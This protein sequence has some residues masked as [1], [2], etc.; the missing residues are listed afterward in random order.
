MCE[1][2]HLLDPTLKGVALRKLEA[3]VDPLV[4]IL[5]A[6]SDD[7][8]HFLDPR[9]HSNLNMETNLIRLLTMTTILFW[10]LSE[11]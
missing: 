3:K 8:D 11:I 2:K 6:A 4:D 10:R 7:I 9:P 1:S 5:A